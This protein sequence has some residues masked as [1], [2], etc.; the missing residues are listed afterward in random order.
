MIAAGAVIVK[1]MMEKI[2]EASENMFEGDVTVTKRDCWLVAAILLLSGIALG[3]ICAPLTHGVSINL[4]SNNG[5]DSGNENGNSYG[6]GDGGDCC[7]QEEE[8]AEEGA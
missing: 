8:A 2:K 3:F 6:N 7:C 5:N 4:F 1:R